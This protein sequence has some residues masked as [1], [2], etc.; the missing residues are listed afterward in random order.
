VCSSTLYSKGWWK[1]LEVRLQGHGDAAT[2][3]GP[4]SPGGANICTVQAW[5]GRDKPE[6]C[7]DV[8]GAGWQ[9]HGPPS[10]PAHALP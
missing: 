8:D 6:V 3:G 9:A 10:Q 2:G 1:E 7:V 4:G 5:S